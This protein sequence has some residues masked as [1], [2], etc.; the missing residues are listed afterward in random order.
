MKDY[1][2]H[3]TVDPIQFTG[4]ESFEFRVT[5]EGMVDQIAKTVVNLQEKRIREGLIALGWTPP[6]EEDLK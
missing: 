5:I 6:K 2:T 3:I 1:K 4:P